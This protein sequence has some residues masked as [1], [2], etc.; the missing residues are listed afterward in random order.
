[1]KEWS[2]IMWL[3]TRSRTGNERSGSVKS[4]GTYW[5]ASN[6]WFRKESCVSCSYLANIDETSLVGS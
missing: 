4:Q 1:M 5:Q 2:G 6:C 3:G